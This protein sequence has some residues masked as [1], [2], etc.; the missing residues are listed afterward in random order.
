MREQ[1]P[2][3]DEDERKPHF[4]RS[5][6]EV[7]VGE[8]P[9]RPWGISVPRAQ[10][11][12]KSAM[13]SNKGSEPAGPAQPEIS[14]PKS[15]QGDQ[16]RKCPVDHGIH[17]AIPDATGTQSARNTP[18]PKVLGQE[19]SSYPHIVFNGPVFFGYSAEQ[20]AALLQ[21]AGLGNQPH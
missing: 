3:D 14:I 18:A 17:N 21:S 15:V 19:T 1:I 12:S 6:R 4:A 9:S 8:S 5:L 11:P 20:A 13:L 7:R 2:P 16:V 10:K